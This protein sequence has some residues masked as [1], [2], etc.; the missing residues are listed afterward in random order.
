MFITNLYSISPQKTFDNS[1]F[2]GEVKSFFGNKYYGQEPDYSAL[3]PKGLLRRLGKA[4]KI[5]LGAGIPLIETKKDEA[6]DFLNNNNY[7]SIRKLS[8][9]DFLFEYNK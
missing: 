2:D 1:F 6:I 3:I 5:G 8:H 4:V 7:N 9:H